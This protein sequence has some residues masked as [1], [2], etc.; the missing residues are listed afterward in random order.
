MNRMRSR[1]VMPSL[2]LLVLGAGNI[3]VGTYKSY[4]YQ[5]VLDALSL[6]EPQAS[7]I[8]TSPLRRLQ[9]ERLAADRSYHRQEQATAKRD[10]YRLVSFGGEVFVALSILL[11]LIEAIL[12]FTPK[13]KTKPHA[14]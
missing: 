1:L 10:F 5:D 14:Q 11:L 7:L 3:G 8:T 6:Q 2:F 4:Q 13:K 9:L 12:R